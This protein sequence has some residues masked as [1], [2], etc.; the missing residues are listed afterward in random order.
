MVDPVGIVDSF[1]FVD[2]LD[3]VF[4]DFLAY[5]NAN[6]IYPVYNEVH[7]NGGN[8]VPNGALNNDYA[9]GTKF[10]GCTY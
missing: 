1:T 8:Y 6:A 4:I 3:Y 2:I 5:N 9:D 7:P 10:N